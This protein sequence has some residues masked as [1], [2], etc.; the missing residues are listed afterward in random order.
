MNNQK[1]RFAAL[2][3]NAFP[4]ADAGSNRL[5]SIAKGINESLS[6]MVIY[7]VRPSEKLPNI[8]NKDAEGEID[9]VKYI[10]PVGT[11]IWPEGKINRILIYLKGIF[12]TWKKISSKN[13]ENKIDVLFSYSYSIPLNLIFW[14]FTKT[15]KM[16]FVYFVDEYP[17]S[18]LFPEKYG[19]LYKSFDL[20]LFYKIFDVILVMT[21]PLLEFY[22][23]R[24]NKNTIIEVVPMTVQPERFEKFSG[25]SPEKK[26]YFLYAGFLG[27]NKDGVDILIKAFGIFSK[28]FP[29]IYLYILGYSDKQEDHDNLKLLAEN[30]GV[31]D[32][33]IFTGKIHRDEIP[34]YFCNATALTLSR[35]DNIQAKGGFPTKLGEYLATGN[36]VVVTRVGEIPHYL[37]DGVNA[38]TSEPDSVEAFA[39][40]LIEVM[41][42]PE[43][44][45]KIGAEG[46]KLTQDV[47][48]NGVQAKRIIEIISG[49]ILNNEKNKS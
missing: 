13:K 38:F 16:K 6:E 17:Y 4:V 36:P 2:F 22:S 26:P 15:H 42:D 29:E 32:R 14:L 10:Y 43:R 46:K 25:E 19:F 23:E 9:G 30:N 37:K 44:A 40:K 28:K 5:L 33:V 49:Y 27:D 48:N 24:K 47:F 1:L 20:K 21:T 41:D 3:E 34:R 12:A 35:P 39:D 7:C 45:R 8:I 31:G 11:T 18:I